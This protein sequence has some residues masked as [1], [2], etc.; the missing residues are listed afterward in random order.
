MAAEGADAALVEKFVSI[1][2]APESKAHA[3]LNAYNGNLEMAIG[4]YLEDGHGGT[5]PYES[6][7]EN[8]NV[9]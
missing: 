9:G 5:Q 6:Q 7:M 2:G 1:T 4:V 3:L 8:P